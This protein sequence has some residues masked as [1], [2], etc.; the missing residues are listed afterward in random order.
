MIVIGG[1]E[2]LFITMIPL[3]FIDGATVKN[4][5]RLGWAV[6]FGIVTF[7]WWQLLLNQ[8]AVVPE[9]VRADQRPGRPRSR[10][11]CSC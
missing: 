11:A 3:T 4:W 1:L 7:L 2:G 10:S 9:R 8:D 6:V 5:S